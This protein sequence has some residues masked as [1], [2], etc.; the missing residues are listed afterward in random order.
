M[1]FKR[2]GD[3]VVGDMVVGTKKKGVCID[4]KTWVAGE[5]KVR[6]VTQS[7]TK[8]TCVNTGIKLPC[9]VHLAGRNVSL[10]LP[11][12]ELVLV[13]EFPTDLESMGAEWPADV[14]VKRGDPAADGELAARRDNAGFGERPSLAEMESL[15]TPVLDEMSVRAMVNS[16]LRAARDHTENDWVAHAVGELIKAVRL[17]NK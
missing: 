7:V 4:A 15:M 3:L 2:A 5:M 10:I 1:K 17:L 6:R 11:Q 9:R 16:H 14:P 12:A 13:A 8:L